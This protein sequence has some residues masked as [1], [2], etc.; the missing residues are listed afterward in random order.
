[1]AYGF[2]P[3]LAKV[4]PFHGAFYAVI[5]SVTKVVAMGGSRKDIYLSFQEYFEKLGTKDESWGKPLAALLGGLQVQRELGIPAIG[6]KDSMSGTFMDINVPPALISFAITTADASKVISTEFKKK[7]SQIVLLAAKRDDRYLIEFESYRASMDRIEELVSKGKILAANT[8][9][10]GGVF[11]ALVKMAVGNKIGLTVDEITRAELNAASYGSM[12]ME[13]S[14][15]E[16][17]DRLFK[18][19]EYKSRRIFGR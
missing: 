9:G 14:K 18:G 16:D 10:K 8:I 19:V 12:V 3:Q 13:I 2:D 1:M 15:K 4:S 7:D 17:A 11:M 6:G 5:D